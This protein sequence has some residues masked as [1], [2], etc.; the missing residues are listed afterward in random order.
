[1]VVSVAVLAA[2][3]VGAWRAFGPSSESP[4]TREPTTPSGSFLTLPKSATAALGGGTSHITVT[5]T[6]QTNLPDGTIVLAK[7]ETGP[8][9]GGGPQGKGVTILS[10]NTVV[11]DGELQARTDEPFCNYLGSGFDLTIE[12]RPFYED[13]VVPGPMGSGSPS[14][15]PPTQPE[16]VLQVLGDHFQDLT[17]NEV[18]S[19]DSSRGPI[20]Q[21]VVTGSYDW[22]APPQGFA[23][24]PCPTPAP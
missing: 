15:W 18:T 9:G 11:H 8:H 3:G 20:N 10:V 4:P 2:A 1:M 17:G 13:W 24:P 21:I 22:P 5:V 14:P 6:A 7:W 19:T 12:V 16:S 23:P